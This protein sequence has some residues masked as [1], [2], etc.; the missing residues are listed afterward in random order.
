MFKIITV[1]K[2][3][4][5]IVVLMFQM[6]SAI[7]AEPDAVQVQVLGEG[8][9]KALGVTNR[10][11]VIRI[12]KNLP[13]QLPEF[14][15]DI[16]NYELTEAS[17]GRIVPIERAVESGFSDGGLYQNAV[18]VAPVQAGVNYRLVLKFPD[19]TISVP[20]SEIK[21]DSG[22]ILDLVWQNGFANIEPLLADN[23][24]SA[25]LRF[26]LGYSLSE[27]FDINGAKGI[28]FEPQEPT[29]DRPYVDVETVTARLGISG[30]V[31][32]DS[33]DEQFNNA[34]KGGLDFTYWYIPR[35]DLKLDDAQS[36][37]GKR[38]L[39]RAYPIGVKATPFE[40]E[41]TQ[42][43]DLL[44]YTTKF[45]LGMAVPYTDIPG[46]ILGSKRRFLPM[47]ISTGYSYVKDIRDDDSRN[48]EATHRWDGEVAYALPITDDLN[49][50]GRWRGY[51]GIE[52]GDYEDQWSVEFRL[53]L[54][55]SH[56]TAITAGFR[57]GGSPPEFRDESTFLAGFSI[58]T[59]TK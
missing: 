32:S 15:Q 51:Y 45:Q 37:S 42:D 22:S 44:D 25:G 38:K 29:P 43:F 5:I 8:E 30:E 35:F 14:F 4:M 58:G 6:S 46:F 3:L 26:G 2:L 52:S 19:E 47:Y 27:P 54:D 41:A 55:D 13:K 1:T 49:L 17:T 53:W 59:A 39:I 9:R 12:L 11:Y 18:I 33:D 24:D 10:N 23:A 36:P 50:E 48:F 56:T 21:D 40:L 31:S 34:L 16:G 7:A 57:Q 28:L 20:V